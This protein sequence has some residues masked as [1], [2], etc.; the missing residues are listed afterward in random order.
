MKK[1]LTRLFWGFVIAILIIIVS[2]IFAIRE[3]FHSAFGPD[4]DDFGKR[5]QI[6]AGLVY[7]QPME[8]RD[9]A[10]VAPADSLAPDSYLQVYND[11]QG[12][13]YLYD[14]HYP[15]LPAGEIYLECYE[16]TENIP[17]SKNRILE[18]SKV[19]ITVTDSFSKLINKQKFT[20][21]EGVW[22]DYYAARIEVWHKDATTKKKRKLVEK[23]YRVEGWER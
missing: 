15:S 3:A 10:L 22:G 12:G 5:H 11:Y 9:S 2:F 18:E 23:V 4:N 7:N 14:F 21:Y 1:F 16:V 13:M 8:L 6:P 17:L 19:E 20:I